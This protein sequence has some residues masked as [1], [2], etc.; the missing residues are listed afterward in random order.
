MGWRI[1]EVKLKGF[2]FFKDEFSISFD[3]C[4]VLL[5][6]ENGSGKSSIY[7]SLYTIFQACL[8]T[9]EDAQ[10]YYK[11]GHNQNLRNRFCMED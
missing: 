6:G 9:Q 8:K 2:K 3:G 11:H 10:K 4:H 5:Y 1:K 7:W